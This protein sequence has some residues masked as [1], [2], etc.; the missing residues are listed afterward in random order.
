MFSK[1]FWKETAER[2]AKS[3]AQALLGLAL[4]DGGTNA[5]SVDWKMVA[6]V[7]AGAA[8]LSVLTSLVSAPFGKS[9]SPSLVDGAK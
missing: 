2:A 4:L 8:A 6:G 1:Q 5:L 7:A 9:G 3:V